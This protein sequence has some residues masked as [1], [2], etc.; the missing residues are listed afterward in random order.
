MRVSYVMP[1]SVAT[2]FGGHET[3]GADWRIWPEDVAEIVSDVL[4]SILMQRGL[5]SAEWKCG[6][7]RPQREADRGIGQADR[8]MKSVHG[9]EKLT[10]AEKNPLEPRSIQENGI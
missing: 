4:L 9:A 7:R 2:G 10:A 1:G 5:W 8:R 6:P 3:V